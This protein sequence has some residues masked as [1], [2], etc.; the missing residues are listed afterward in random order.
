MSAVR[1]GAS[2]VS[3]LAFGL[4]LAG[5]GSDPAPEADNRSVEQPVVAQPAP[6]PPPGAPP[7]PD[8]PLPPLPLCGTEGPPS[9]PLTLPGGATIPGTP[10]PCR[11]EVMPA[12]PYA[13]EPEPARPEAPPAVAAPEAADSR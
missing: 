12:A 11:H 1:P 3:T 2:L 8:A 6:P 9:P 5:C 10:K 7:Q 13:G 4:M